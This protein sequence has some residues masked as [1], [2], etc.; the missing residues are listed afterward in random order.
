MT[1]ETSSVKFLFNDERLFT[2]DGTVPALQAMKTPDG[3][4]VYDMT[5]PLRPV[6]QIPRYYYG[7]GGTTLRNAMFVEFQ[8]LS[9]CEKGP[10]FTLKECCYNGY[11]SLKEIYLNFEDPTEYEFANAVLG[12]WDVWEGIAD[13]SV[14]CKPVIAKWRRELEIRLRAKG[15]SRISHLSKESSNDNIVLSASRFLAE[16]GWCSSKGES[17][18][19]T[20][21]GR[22]R[23]S[24]ADIEGELKRQ[25][26]EESL[27][28]AQAELVLSSPSSGV[29]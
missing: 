6:L 25:A 13:K 18:T 10:F 15:I 4:H 14:T 2:K 27:I 17:T 7:G 8:A 12:S 21:K 20:S 3:R 19:K 5:N 11:P 28:K 24:K 16:A 29:N 23:P 22:G 9:H 1:D 26:E